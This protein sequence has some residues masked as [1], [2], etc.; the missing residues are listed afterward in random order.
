MTP[1]QRLIKWLGE[2][3]VWKRVARVHTALYRRTGGRVGARLAG[4]PHLL[5]TTTGRRS[6]EPR[7]LPL[8]YMSDRGADGRGEQRWVV[9]ASNGGSDRAP[10][11]WRNLEARPEAVIE[12]GAEEHRVVAHRAAGEE[13]ARLWA[14]VKRF[15]PA[16][17]TY[18]RLTEREIPVVVLARA[19]GAGG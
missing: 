19:G 1:S 15:N 4:L 3:G 6:G 17:A 7:T 14:E 11:W 10:A 9:V 12:V 5:L 13:R 18:E 16:Y 8:V 2:S